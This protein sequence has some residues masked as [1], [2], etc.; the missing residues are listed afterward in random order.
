MM[1]LMMMILMTMMMMILMVMVTILM[2]MLMLV[3]TVTGGR[4][5]DTDFGDDGESRRLG[6]PVPLAPLVDGVLGVR[7]R[8]SFPTSS[9]K[10]AKKQNMKIAHGY[11]RIGSAFVPA[12]PQR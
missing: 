1:I 8:F 4:E 9:H 5:D 7:L 3:M 10:H 11:D 12:A 6:A 2:M